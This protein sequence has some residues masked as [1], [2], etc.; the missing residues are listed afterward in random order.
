MKRRLARLIASA[1][2][3]AGLVAAALLCMAVT[4]AGAAWQPTKPVTFV[5][6]GGAGGG[7][8]QMARLIQGIASK[9][10]L[11]PQPLVVV[12][13][14]GGGGGQ[15]F[16]DV[17]NSAGDAHK[18]MIVLA[19]V[20][21]VPLSTKLPFNWRDITPVSLMALD[22]FVLWVN[23]SAPYRTLP[24]FLKAVKAAPAETFKLGGAG[25]KREDEIVTAMI[26]SVAVLNAQRMPF[27]EPVADGKSWNDIPTCRE[28]GM[29]AQYM[30]LRAIMMP[31]GV[32]AEQQAF[33]VNLMKRVKET[34]E[35]KEFIDRGAYNDRF[36][37]GEAFAR[38]LEED[39]KRHRDIM[40]KAGFLAR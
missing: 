16:M 31:K 30:M 35:W 5:V 10:K 22:E 25:R 33:Y 32:S 8:D 4:T 19:N 2:R 23:S 39:E 3:R 9:H 37:S 38:F 40:Q 17:K 20:H 18:I 1:N 14:N 15:G 6:T 12:I 26:E 13:M 29:D 11:S 24:E 27:K 34:P 28:E 36:L 7:A 21:S